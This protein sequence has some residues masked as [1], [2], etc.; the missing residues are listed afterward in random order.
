MDEDAALTQFTISYDAEGELGAH[1]IDAED[2]GNAIIGMNDLITKAAKIVSGGTSEAALKVIAPAKEGSLE[3]I[4][5]IA[6]DP[7]TTV[8]VLRTIG[9]GAASAAAYAGSVIGIMDRLKDK[10]IDRVEINPKSQKAV[11]H[12]GDEKIEASPKVANLVSSKDIRQALHK[13]IQ[14]PLEGHKSA[15]IKF[16]TEERTT[17]LNENE[18]KNFKPIKS[19]VIEKQ[20]TTKF[21]KVVQFTKL[22]FKSKRGWTISSQDGL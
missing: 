16:I 4:F 12:A 18:I 7:Q 9:I 10:K 14:A 8:S 21:E 1:T 13:V 11:I 6:A 19:D 3:I 22:N 17:E 2:L 20:T 15:A 5:A